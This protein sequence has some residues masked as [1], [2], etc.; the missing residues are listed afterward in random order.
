MSYESFSKS[1]DLEKNKRT[2][3]RREMRAKEGSSRKERERGERLAI[4]EKRKRD[5]EEA[6]FPRT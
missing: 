3:E 1:S 4:W 6:W 5:A 2:L